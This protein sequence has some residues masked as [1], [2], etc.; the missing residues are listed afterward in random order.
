MITELSVHVSTHCR[1]W[2]VLCYTCMNTEELCI[3]VLYSWYFTAYWCGLRQDLNMLPDPLCI[4]CIYKATCCMT[5]RPDVELS[6]AWLKMIWTTYFF[7][8]CVQTITV[9]RLCC[10]FFIPVLLFIF[11]SALLIHGALNMLDS[12]C[13]TLLF[14]R[15]HVETSFTVVSAVQLWL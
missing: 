2:H 4:W 1:E 11:F 7:A 14:A 8:C 13:C 12:Q 10:P 15:F 3:P 5:D 6:T 9:S